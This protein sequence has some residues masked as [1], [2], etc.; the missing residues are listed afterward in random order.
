MLKRISITSALCLCATTG[1]AGGLSDPIIPVAPP[2]PVPVSVPLDWYAG[3]QLGAA[4]GS[5]DPGEA[6]TTF[7]ETDDRAE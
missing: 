1:F 6:Q 4:N 7:R 5:F 2:A 3:I